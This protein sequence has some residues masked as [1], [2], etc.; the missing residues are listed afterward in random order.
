M[1]LE[2]SNLFSFQEQNLKNVYFSPCSGILNLK[3][4]E[5]DKILISHKPSNSCINESE[6]EFHATLKSD[7]QKATHITN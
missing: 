3:I 7:I 1:I 5:E 2:G 6:F 4:I